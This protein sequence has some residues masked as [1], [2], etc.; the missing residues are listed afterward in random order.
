M[1]AEKIA[2]HAA[3]CAEQSRSFLPFVGDTGGG[4]G[5]ATFTYWLRDVYAADQRRQRADGDDGSAS[6]F[7]LEHLLRELLAVL[8]RDK[9]QDD[10][11]PGAR[12]LAPPP[13]TLP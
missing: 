11:P 2:K 10:R 6:R 8:V 12:P 3:G 5:P 4:I 7:A 13:A 1:Y 9:L